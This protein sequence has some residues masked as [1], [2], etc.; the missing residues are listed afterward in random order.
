MLKCKERGNKLHGSDFH[1]IIWFLVHLSWKQFLILEENIK[2]CRR[3][4]KSTFFC[5]SSHENVPKAKEA[6]LETDNQ[7]MGLLCPI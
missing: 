5:I 7:Q 2:V 1:F 3:F 4:L 6:S